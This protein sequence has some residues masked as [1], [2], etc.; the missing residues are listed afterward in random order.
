MVTPSLPQTE[1]A[2]TDIPWGGCQAA[3]RREG[4]GPHQSTGQALQHPGPTL[5]HRKGSSVTAVPGELREQPLDHLP[6][7]QSAASRS[8]GSWTRP[9]TSVGRLWT[10]SAADHSIGSR[11]SRANG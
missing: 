3:V 2:L 6:W 4:A 11:R 1:E 5:G 7:V 9:S 8:I 10:R